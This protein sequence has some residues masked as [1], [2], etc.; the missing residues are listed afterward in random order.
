[1]EVNAASGIERGVGVVVVRPADYP[2]DVEGLGR[3][4]RDFNR[5]ME[6]TRTRASDGCRTLDAAAHLPAR[7]ARALLSH[8]L[9]QTPRA[10]GTMALTVLK[11]A[12]V[13]GAPLAATGH[14]HGFL[15]MGGV[16]LPTAGGGKVGCITVKGP[17]GVAAGYP[18]MLRAA[19]ARCDALP[20]VA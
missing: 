6:L 3:Y 2:Q 8:A 15:A 19:M 4:V 20:P 5:A 13:F 11:D 7:T 14:G 10:F 18:A 12:R 9:E 16:A 17:K 1:V